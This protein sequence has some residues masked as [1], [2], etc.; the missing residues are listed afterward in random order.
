VAE[1]KG[2]NAPV[3]LTE[4]ASRE[5]I[6]GLD[7]LE[8]RWSIG[9]GGIGLMLTSIFLFVTQ[10]GYNTTDPKNGSCPSGYDLVK[11]VCQQ[12]YELAFQDYMGQFLLVLI[13][14]LFIIFFAWRKR[15]VGVIFAAFMMGLALGNVGLPFLFLGGWL[16][17][18]AFRLQKYG[19]PTF[20]GSNQQSRLRAQ[21]RAANR[22]KGISN[23]RR[24][25]SDGDSAAT[26][27]RPK[28]APSKRYT[29]KQSGR[30]R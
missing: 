24:T 18:R 13:G 26:P 1:N 6:F 8:R 21:Q 16:G 17:I 30:R 28:P 27:S 19:T 12:K 7:A 10:Y 2:K 4:G 11:K 23:S 15:R 20:V 3:V 29:P 22:K 25:K 9:I 5:V 14:A